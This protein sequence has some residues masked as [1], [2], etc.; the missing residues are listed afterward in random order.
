MKT[1]RYFLIM[2]I[3]GLSP[4][5]LAGSLEPLGPPGQMD[6][7]MYSINDI[8]E[9]LKSGVEPELTPWNAPTNGPSDSVRCTLND[10][11]AVAPKKDAANS[12]QASEV[13][14]GK[15]YWSLR[16]DSWGK[17]IGTM[18]NQGAQT[19][20]PKT[21]DQA[22]SA[23][24]H[25]GQGI[26]K[27]DVDLVATNLKANVEIFGITGNYN[28]QVA[29]GD[30]QASEVLEGKTFSNS[31]GTDF[32]GKMP[33]QGAQTYIPSTIDQVIVAGYHNGQGIVKGDENLKA[34]NL[35][36]GVELFGVVGSYECPPVVECPPVAT[37]TAVVSEVLVGKTFSTSQG[38]GLVG[39]MVDQGAKNYTPSTTDQPIVAG[40]YNG[41]GVVKGDVNL[42]ANNIKK[43][44]TLFGVAGNPNVVDTNSGDAVAT[45]ILSGK[46]A[47]VDG[48]EVT[49]TGQLAIALSSVPKTSQTVCYDAVG[50]VVSCSGTGQD[51]E[52][53]KGVMTSPRFTDNGNGTVTDNLTGLIWLKDANC[54]GQ[55]I[56]AA[57][58]ASANNL[59]N[60]SCG[61]SDGSGGGDWRLPN[62]NELLS[63]VDSGRYDPALPSD[64]PFLNVNP[65]YYWSATTYAS[66]TNNA[67]YVY[68]YSGSTHPS[69]KATLT[70]Y[71]WPVRGGQ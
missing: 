39:T 29:T 25:N 66:G 51:G 44:I 2:M 14:S 70:Y 13:L 16:E 63:L 41:S 67:W 34:S 21:T 4:L 68:F 5:S 59:S 62:K 18:V 56:W 27:G 53:Q 54:F 37:G 12:A 49:G 42:V 71:V 45:E 58:L 36:K 7:A 15:S 28:P 35:L 17:Q 9:R 61:L 24:Y 3:T 60:G 1:I 11:M 22:I 33:N 40:Y 55:Q 30:V 10:V 65:D 57:A 23:G 6:S 32:D 19:Y 31:Q 43:G 26:V 50:S 64:H 46:K 52:Y 69:D 20:I 48:M 38:V 47:W 8:C